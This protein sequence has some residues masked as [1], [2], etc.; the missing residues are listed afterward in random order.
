MVNKNC[1]LTCSKLFYLLFFE[2]LINKHSKQEPELLLDGAVK[3]YDST[4]LK[5]VRPGQYQSLMGLT[6]LLIHYLF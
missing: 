3:I 5:A 4:F 2:M 6:K 1:F